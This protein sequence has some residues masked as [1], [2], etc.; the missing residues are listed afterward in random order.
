[1]TEQ[2]QPIIERRKTFIQKHGDQIL[3]GAMLAGILA[4]FTLIFSM[5]DSMQQVLTKLEFFEQ[6]VT[7]LESNFDRYQ[8]KEAAR[9]AWE[10]QALRDEMAKARVEQLERT[11]MREKDQ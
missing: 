9:A 8:T 10:A 11:F 2:G 5:N 6:R 1:V 4:T 3:S 7:T